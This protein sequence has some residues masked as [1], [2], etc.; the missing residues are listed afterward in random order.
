MHLAHAHAHARQVRTS[1]E[2]LK[3][4]TAA[5]SE[6]AVLTDASAEAKRCG[7]ERLSVS[8]D[9]AKA[10]AAEFEAKRSHDEAVKSELAARSEQGKAEER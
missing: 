8:A 4:M 3:E 7:A 9:L 1:D 5:R 6:L 10:R 2:K